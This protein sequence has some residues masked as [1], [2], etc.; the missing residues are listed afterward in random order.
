MHIFNEKLERL[1]KDVKEELLIALQES[2]FKQEAI[3]DACGTSQGTISKWFSYNP[4]HQPP[5]W[6]LSVLP[7]EI[8]VPMCRFFLKRFGCDVTQPLPVLR[9]NGN[10]DDECLGM[11]AKLGEII[12]DVKQN[13][14]KVRRL[15][16]HF[17]ELEAILR[18]GR[19]EV[20]T[21]A[22]RPRTS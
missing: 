10:L 20:T 18:Q 9:L 1:A 15:L 11:A 6:I 17:D 14:D 2:P 19:E 22:T 3:A 21:M 5:L 8:V 7:E 12:T 13:P 4:D 16:K